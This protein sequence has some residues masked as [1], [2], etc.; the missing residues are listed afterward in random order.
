M[1]SLLWFS[2][3][4]YVLS[5]SLQC[6]MQYIHGL[7]QDYC[8]SSA[9]AM[10]I[11]QSCAKPSIYWYFILHY[12]ATLLNDSSPKVIEKKLIIPPGIETGIFR[13]TE[14]CMHRL[15]ASQAIRNH[16]IDPID[17]GLTDLYHPQERILTIRTISVLLEIKKNECHVF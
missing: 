16:R 6:C 3:P 14:Y 17:V 13:E 4:I 11:P 5:Q 12:V 8:I 9:L 10:E 7:V 2:T 1:G 15:F